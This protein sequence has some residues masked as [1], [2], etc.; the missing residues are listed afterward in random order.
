MP[1]QQVDRYLKAAAAGDITTVEDCLAAGVDIDA[2]NRQRQ[3]A[4]LLAAQN[5]H[6][7]LI[8]RLIVTSSDN[9]I[10]AELLP[11]HIRQS[12]YTPR[13]GSRLSEAVAEVEAYLLETSFRAHGAWPKVAEELGIDKAT[14]YRKAGKY[15]LLK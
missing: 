8:E 10:D 6:Y 3:T 15:G 13:R 11:G 7:D 9:E 14:A 5:Q 4:I 2:V 1:D 12:A